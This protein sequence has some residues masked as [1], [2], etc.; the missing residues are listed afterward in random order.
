MLRK[1]KIIS[2]DKFCRNSEW[3][4]MSPA[5]V[6]WKRCG[7]EVGLGLVRQTEFHGAKRGGS[8]TQESTRLILGE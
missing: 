2:S 7:G 8:K 5:D 4:V 6:L 3:E 1:I